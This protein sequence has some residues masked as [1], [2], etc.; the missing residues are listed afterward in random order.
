[1]TMAEHDG[2]KEA[3]KFSVRETATLEKFEVEEG[4]RRLIETIRLVDGVIVSV[5]RPPNASQGG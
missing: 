4:G 1:M 2:F 3:N 5:E